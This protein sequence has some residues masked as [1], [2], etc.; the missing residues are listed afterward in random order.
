MGGNF[1]LLYTPFVIVLL[2]SFI[3]YK[4]YSIHKINNRWELE[5]LSIIPTAFLVLYLWIGVYNPAVEDSR[6][7]LRAVLILSLS[8]GSHVAYSYSK[9]LKKGGK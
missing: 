1:L 2:S 9:S 4:L 8:V 7:W 5:S 6:A 3:L